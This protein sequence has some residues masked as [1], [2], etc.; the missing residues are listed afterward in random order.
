MRYLLTSEV[1]RILNT[2]RPTVRRLIKIGELRAIKGE[3]RN[4]RVKIE[5]DS[6]KEYIERHRVQVDA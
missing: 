5:E 6:V 2:S 3:G 1:Q 4:G